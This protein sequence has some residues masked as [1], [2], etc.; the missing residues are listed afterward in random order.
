M[1]VKNMFMVR[2][3]Y[4]VMPHFETIPFVEWTA[5]ICVAIVR[6]SSTILVEIHSDAQSSRIERYSSTTGNLIPTRITIDHCQV[7]HCLPYMH[8]Y[9]C[10]S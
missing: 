4:L 10:F 6:E 9:S 7:Q 2:S 3:R 1:V 5:W 8:H